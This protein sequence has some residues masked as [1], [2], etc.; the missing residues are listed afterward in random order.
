MAISKRRKER[1]AGKKLD[2]LPHDGF[3]AG[4]PIKGSGFGRLNPG[5]K[6]KDQVSIDSHDR[7]ARLN[8]PGKGTATRRGDRFLSKTG[9]SFGKL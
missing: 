3:F 8:K 4:S 9:F 1:A 5:V 7:G 6:H 2:N